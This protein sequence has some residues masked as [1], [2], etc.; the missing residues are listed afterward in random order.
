MKG[1]NRLMRAVIVSLLSSFVFVFGIGCGT[2]VLAQEYPA[3]PIDMIISMAPGA[4]CDIGARLVAKAAE[5][6]LGKEIVPINKAGGG[7]SLAAGLVAKAKPDGYTIL[8]TVTATLTNTPHMEAVTYKAL[9]DFIPVFEHGYLIPAF[10]V[11]ADSPY[12]TMKDVVEAARKNPGKISFGTP[13]A[14]TSPDIAAQMIADKEK[15]DMAVVS[16]GGSA[17]S[18]TALLGGHITV[19]GVSTPAAIPQVRGGKARGLA[20]MGSKRADG[21]T[22]TATLAE[23]GYPDITLEELY[24]IAVPKG[25]PKAIVE[26]LENA[27]RKGWADEGAYKSTSKAMF[28]YP[29]NP[30]SGAKLYDWLK[31]QYTTNGAI[32]KKANLGK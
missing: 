8:A 10:I 4:A 9:E 25:T 17:P 23:Q 31:D 30:M 28:M 14:G 27:L 6:Y 22:E 16:M 32:I 11:R 7:G 29:E 13:G 1:K 21:L 19:A 24:I 3:R 15:V 2:P 12:K 18:I 5:K 20:T 26:K